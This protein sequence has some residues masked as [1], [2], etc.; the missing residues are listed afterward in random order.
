MCGIAGYFGPDL[1]SDERI[2]VTLSALRHRGPDGL[3]R[4]VD[5]LNCNNIVFLHTRLAIIDLDKRSNQPFHIHNKTLIFNGEIYNHVELRTELQSLGCI[6][7]T[8]SDTEVLAYS[9]LKWGTKAMDKLEGM[10][11]FAWFDK[12]TN[13]LLLSRDRFGE[14]PLYLWNKDSGLFFASEIKALAALAGEWPNINHNHLC[15][16]LVNGYKSLFKTSEDF[17]ID[18][19]QLTPGQNL[20]ISSSGRKSL[21][22]YWQ[23]VVAEKKVTDYIDLVDEVKQTLINSVALRMRADVP[24][25]F[26]MSGGIDSN[27][28]IS[29]AKRE[30]GHKVHGFTIVNT[31]SRY[32]EEELITHSVEKLNIEHTSVG[33][34]Q[35]TFL[36]GLSELITSHSMP[37]ATITYFVHWQLM[38]AIKKAGYK[39]TI[40][41][42]G[43]DELFSGYYDH[44]NLYLAAIKDNPTLHQDSAKAWMKYQAPLIRNPHLRDPDLFSNCPTFRDHIYLNNDDFSSY[45]TTPWTEDFYE[46][47][48]PNTTI[49]RNRMLNELL[50]EIVPVILREDD[51][52]AMHYSL[53]NRSPFLDRDLA[54]LSFSIPTELLIRDGFAKVVLRD[55]MRGIVPEA[56]LDNREKVGFNAPIESLLDTHNPRIREA[57]LDDSPVFSHVKKSAI[58]QLLDKTNLPNSS[59]KFLFNFLNTKFFLEKGNNA[60]A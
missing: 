60:Q 43:A 33:L 36:D 34:N 48:F 39:V 9:L 13:E 27:S 44:H 54:Q 17:Y 40:S 30:L 31:D 11:S 55:A 20:L 7:T 42:T 29:I 18:V 50:H 49:L 46:S 15:R 21:H 8:Q 45:L 28:L 58:E 5:S 41:G 24:V 22:K 57:L 3:G 38:S 10:W 32:E 59:S 52:N 25:A 14:K 53:E 16:Y 4:Y 19:H 35:D 1:P 37:I 26:C 23:P 51:F 2:N 56:I 6:F 47:Q 12:N